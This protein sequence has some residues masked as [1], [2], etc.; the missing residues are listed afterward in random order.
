MTDNTK[1]ARMAQ[2]QWRGNQ[3]TSEDN[4]PD[5]DIEGKS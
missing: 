3:H 2:Y 5:K 4:L 1:G